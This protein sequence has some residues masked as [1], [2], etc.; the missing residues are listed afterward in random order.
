[1]EQRE[2]SCIRNGIGN[3]CQLADSYG[4]DK[5]DDLRCVAGGPFSLY[6]LVKAEAL[7]TVTWAMTFPDQFHVF[8]CPG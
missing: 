1:M 4:Q 8:V 6:G 7:S 5:T 2:N 3:G